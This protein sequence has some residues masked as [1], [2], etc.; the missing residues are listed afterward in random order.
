MKIDLD[1][2]SNDI[3]TP[4]H[5]KRG[6]NFAAPLSQPDASSRASITD[7]SRDGQ[8]SNFGSIRPGSPTPGGSTQSISLTSSV[9]LV[10]VPT[11]SGVVVPAGMATSPNVIAP[12]PKKSMLSAEAGSKSMNSVRASLTFS[13]DG[14]PAQGMEEQGSS[15][16]GNSELRDSSPEIASLD[17]GKGE[18]SSSGYKQH[19]NSAKNPEDGTS[20]ARNVSSIVSAPVTVIGFGPDAPPAVAPFLA[21]PKPA[22]EVPLPVVLTPQRGGEDVDARSKSPNDLSNV[23]KATNQVISPVDSAREGANN[24]KLANKRVLQENLPVS[25]DF[26]R[27]RSLSPMSSIA[28]E[29]NHTSQMAPPS[30]VKRASISSYFEKIVPTSPSP[31]RSNTNMNFNITQASNPANSSH[32]D[33][34]LTTGTSAEIQKLKHEAQKVIDHLRRELE[35]ER[36]AK[37]KLL[38]EN[39]QLA[40]EIS[41][42]ISEAKTQQH[43]FDEERRIAI[44]NLSVLLQRMWSEKVIADRSSLQRQQARLGRFVNYRSTPSDSGDIWEDGEEM[45]ELRLA[46]LRLDEQRQELEHISRETRKKMRKTKE[47]SHPKSKNKKSDDEEEDATM[48]YFDCPLNLSSSTNSI[49]SAHGSLF[50]NPVNPSLWTDLERIQSEETIRLAQASLRREHEVIMERKKALETERALM[51]VESRRQRDQRESKF[52]DFRIFEDRYM[53]LQLLGKGGFSEVWLAY[54]LQTVSEVAVK[55]H[56]L[57]DHWGEEKRASYVRHALREMNIQKSL[58]HPNIVK[59]LSITYLNDTCFATIMEY[60]RG[61]D[62]DK[63]IRSMG[64]TLPERDARAIILQVFAALRHMNGLDNPNSDG[65]TS[66]AAGSKAVES[67]TSGAAASNHAP[68]QRI[69]HYDLKPANILFDEL[70]TVKITDFGLS[71]ILRD[72]TSQ[73]DVTSMELT[74]HGAGTYYYLPPECFQGG[75]ARIS[76]KVDVWSCGVIFYQMLYGKRPFGDGQSQDQLLQQGV[77][78]SLLNKQFTLTFPTTPKVSNEAKE[79]IRRCLTP[80]QEERPDV[81]AISQDPYLRQKMRGT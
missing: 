52:N 15:H 36:K 76:D 1:A 34:K 10:P 9:H 38:Q 80:R 27:P 16:L 33:D 79:F 6:K 46:L 28:T 29:E 22:T 56:Q 64:G 26:A 32:H 43:A 81:Y 67:G 73:Q 44:T 69:I 5:K 68:H 11:V 12:L 75:N 49:L 31:D 51:L 17:W 74:S 25:E 50:S 48:T 57:Q 70:R 35:E 19:T 71:K 72:S 55:I 24:S 40:N 23:E 13:R 30:K 37:Q 53:L 42:L 78:T 60:C 39:E 2:L 77:I 54:D 3:Q 18:S 8:N 65:N 66:D 63:Y 59:L 61:P 4:N 20:S 14:F 7:K 41:R 45:E 62:L 58:V 47:S 21:S